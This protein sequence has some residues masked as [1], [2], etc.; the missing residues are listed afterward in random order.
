MG[1]RREYP[2][3][4]V[5]NGPMPASFNLR[6]MTGLRNLDEDYEETAGSFISPA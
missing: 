4:L 1:E 6:F 5:N 2:A 3:F